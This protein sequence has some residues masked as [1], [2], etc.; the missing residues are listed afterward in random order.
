MSSYST[1]QQTDSSIQAAA[2]VGLIQGQGAAY[3]ETNQMLDNSLLISGNNQGEVIFNQFPEA[4]ASSV[5]ELV[6]AVNNSVTQSAQATLEST[7]ALG[8]KLQD[9]AAGEG[10]TIPKV[11]MYATIGLVAFF[12]LS[13]VVK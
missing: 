11:A 10:S 8:N 7:K 5:K 6:G 2:E 13:K 1:V 4:V 12:V 3:D 9:I